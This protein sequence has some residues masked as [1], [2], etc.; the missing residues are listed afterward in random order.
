MNREISILLIDDDEDDFVITSDILENISNRNYRLDWVST[1]EEGVED[2]EKNKHDVYLIDYRLGS[3]N[4]IELIKDA[5]ARGCKKPLILLTGQIDS[6]IDDQAF[7][8]GAAD[9]IYKGALNEYLIDR[10]IRYSIR[11]NAHIQKIHKLN[12][13]LEERVYVRTRELANAFKKLKQINDNLQNQIEERRTAEKA[14]RQSQRLYK[15]IAH[16]FPNGLILVLDLEMRVIF[17]DGKELEKQKLK[18]EDFLNKPLPTRFDNKEALF[19]EKKLTEVMLGN[20][21][22]FEFRS[23]RGVYGV[24]SVPLF[25]SFGFVKQILLVAQDISEQKAVE[26]ETRKMLKKEKQLNE[27][28]SRFVSTASHEFRT[29]LSSILSSASLISRYDRTDAQPKRMKHVNRIKSNVFNL[30][31]ILNDFLS[32]SKLEEGKMPYK[33]E[34]FDIK[35]YSDELR[36]EMQAIVKTGQEI[37]FEH[38]TK[39]SKVFLDP[40]M[41]KNIIFNLLTNAS[42]YSDAGQ[43]I[44]FRTSVGD[45]IHIEIQDWGIGIPKEDKD[46]MFKRFFR[47]ENATNI[48]GTGLGLN[49]VKKYVGLMGGSIKFASEVNQGTT[50]SLCFPN[51]KK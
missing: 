45:N 49:I 41:Y 32:I 4:G 6:S 33:P 19:L 5:T 42:K 18:Q 40:L 14:L 2:C 7:Q 10:S 50:F 12:E 21:L 47:A 25:N 26:E 30:T 38:Q 22:S 44:E 8:I 27:L 11:Q 31:N 9:Y 35:T 37:H 51:F 29:P 46:H 36:E 28:K 34:N 3:K 20:S 13:E 39:E 43:P 24:D 23:R 48:E 17:V 15:A 1:F 16:N